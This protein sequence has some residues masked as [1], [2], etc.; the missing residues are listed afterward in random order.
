MTKIIIA[1]NMPSEPGF[2]DDPLASFMIQQNK[3]ADECQWC[4][5]YPRSLRAAW[6]WDVR[7]ECFDELQ[8]SGRPNDAY[9]P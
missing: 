4:K 7:D 5:A 9:K 1:C 8:E 2:E 3:G 6:D